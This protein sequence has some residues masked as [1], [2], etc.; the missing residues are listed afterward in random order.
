MTSPPTNMPAPPVPRRSRAGTPMPRAGTPV[1]RAGTPVPHQR[2]SSVP[3]AQKVSAVMPNQRSATPVP[4]GRGSKSAETQTSILP[5]KLTMQQ[6]RPFSSPNSTRSESPGSMVRNGRPKMSKNNSLLLDGIPIVKRTRSLVSESDTSSVSGMFNDSASV[7]GFFNFNPPD[8]PLESRMNSFLT[9]DSLSLL[10]TPRRGRQRRLSETSNVSSMSTRSASAPRKKRDPPKSPA[11]VA[12]PKRGAKAQQTKAE[13]KGATKVT[14]KVVVKRKRGETAESEPAAKKLKTVPKGLNAKAK[15]NKKIKGITTKNTNQIINKVIKVAKKKIVKRI[16]K[17]KEIAGVRKTA[18]K[19]KKMTKVQLAQ[20]ISRNT[21]ESAVRAD[22]RKKNMI[23][24]LAKQNL[25]VNKRAMKGG[26]PVVK[27][28]KQPVADLEKKPTKGKKRE[29]KQSGTVEVPEKSV[30]TNDPP[31]TKKQ[32]GRK[33]QAEPDEPK[34]QDAATETVRKTKNL[35]LKS[36]TV[37]LA[38]KAAGKTVAKGVKKP[39]KVCLP[40]QADTLKTLTQVSKILEKI[41]ERQ[42]DSDEEETKKE[43]EGEQEAREEKKEEKEEAAK[44]E[45]ESSVTTPVPASPKVQSSNSATAEGETADSACNSTEKEK[46]PDS[47]HVSPINT[48]ANILRHKLHQPSPPQ[49]SQAVQTCQPSVSPTLKLAESPQMP[50]PPPPVNGTVHVVTVPQNSKSKTEKP[51]MPPSAPLQRKKPLPIINSLSAAAKQTSSFLR[52]MDDS[53]EIPVTKRDSE[54]QINKTIIYTK[55]KSDNPPVAPQHNTIIQVSPGNFVFGSRKGTSVLKNRN[56]P[57]KALFVSETKTASAPSKVP[58]AETVKQ[59]GD[60]PMSRPDEAL[61]NNENKLDAKVDQVTDNCSVPAQEESTQVISTSINAETEKQVSNSSNLPIPE[62]DKLIIDNHSEPTVV[63][64]AESAEVPAAAAASPLIEAHLDSDK[65]DSSVKQ[66][67]EKSSAG[68]EFEA[69]SSSDASFKTPE[70]TSP[71]NTETEP[72]KDSTASVEP[73][74][75]N[76]PEAAATT[77]TSSATNVNDI[78]SIIPPS[79]LNPD[80]SKRP[81][82]PFEEEDL[83]AKES[84]L[85]ALGLR[86]NHSISEEAKVPKVPK[87]RLVCRPPHKKHRRSTNHDSSASGGYKEKTYTVCREGDPYVDWD[88][89]SPSK[90]TRVTDSDSGTRNL[91]WYPRMPLSN[92]KAVEPMVDGTIAEAG[93]GVGDGP[94]EDATE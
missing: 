76:P 57:V 62:K 21:K 37:N 83:V 39:T 48:L 85:G 46:Q 63:T 35:N 92:G 64:E 22:T 70:C 27:R 79:L 36:S 71:T 47:S 94:G 4:G 44:V 77:E 2:S 81:T 65:T 42:D 12:T 55:M 88:R 32:V 60:V 41:A 15:M 33:K 26:M 11:A 34:M 7:D 66:S 6:K 18:G 73:T 9:P 30:S 52:Q 13:A 8:S 50:P 40:P 14:K 24:K 45:H 75:A 61:D 86:S 17:D 1:P 10:S 31:A 84:V 49:V 56:L 16:S 43:G 69:E 38:P 28:R 51:R 59:N 67:T 91:L 89:P 74:T 3:R 68:V 53:T 29:D 78:F 25:I 19:T 72:P 23:L 82:L 58:E 93:V 87:L 54:Y 5:K 90:S 80:P 20:R